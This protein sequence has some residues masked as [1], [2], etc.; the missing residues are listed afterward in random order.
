KGSTATLA[1][2]S[3]V[4]GRADFVFDGGDNTLSVAGTVG[5]SGN[6]GTA[7][8][9]TAGNG[10]NTVNVVGS[11]VINGGAKVRLGSGANNVSL[12]DAATV[13]ATFT[14]KAAA[15]SKF[16]GSAQPA[17]H[18]TLDLSGFKGT[19]DSSPNP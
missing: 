5:T 13:T 2:G 14:L 18:A 8:T 4:G 12:E 16:H 1:S 9:V 10:A 7:L 3:G 15:A 11:A 19:V 6:T 17:T